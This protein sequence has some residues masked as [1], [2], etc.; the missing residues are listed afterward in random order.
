MKSEESKIDTKEEIVTKKKLDIFNLF[1][2]GAAVVIL[3]GV[4]AKLLEWPAQDLLITAG[5][6][7]EAIVFGV[8]AIKFVEVQVKKEVATEETLAKLADGISSISNNMGSAGDDNSSTYVNI[9]T[10]AFESAGTLSPSTLNTGI[11]TNSTQE[12]DLSAYRTNYVIPKN[13][14]RLDNLSIEINPSIGKNIDSF[15]NQQSATSIGINDTKQF[16]E[17][18]KLAIT[19]LIKDQYFHAE[20]TKL[21]ENE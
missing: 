7:I 18:E 1:Y 15:S 9:Q 14:T 17:L 3:I 4:I 12:F 2:S 16:S 8:S 10:G 20:W 5:L 19:G 11:G 21:N 13:E 6:T